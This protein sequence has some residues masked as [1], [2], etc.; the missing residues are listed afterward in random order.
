[1]KYVMSHF[2]CV[3]AILVHLVQVNGNCVSC[4]LNKIGDNWEKIL[5]FD[6]G[7]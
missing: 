7:V 5:G 3:W 4:N 2:G 6:M 1:V